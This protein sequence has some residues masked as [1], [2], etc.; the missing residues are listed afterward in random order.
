M[1]VTRSWSLVNSACVVIGLGLAVAGCAEHQQR[2]ET[3]AVST[4]QIQASAVA[5]APQPTGSDV[6][7]K[8]QVTAL[9][10][11][12]IVDAPD[13][14]PEDRALDAGRHPVEL[15]KF[16]DLRPGMKVAEIAAGGG[17]TTEL[18]A[19]AVGS[20]G[21]VFGQNSKFVLE[22]FAEKPWSERLKK[23]VMSNVIRVDQPFDDPLPPKAANFD[24]VINV[25]FYHDT[26][27]QKTDRA[28]MNRSIFEAL[29]SGG[30]YVIIDH[31]A[32]AGAGITEAETNHRI[33]ESVVREEIE[34]AGFRLAAS[35]DF[36]R[37]PNDTRD[38][39]ASPRV[40]GERRGTS[41]RFVLKFVKP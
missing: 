34:K 2:A 19:R 24:V 29:R 33:E 30:A 20:T 26:V 6:A 17:Y 7:P 1:K 13:R 9:S 38:W 27:W 10:A 4:V 40:A 22:R 28:R 12:A 16:I 21:A 35:A 11:Q 36:L 41:D 15:L 39:S 5:P 32:R 8:A 18:L 31:S 3:P 37:N 25:L 23:P 14:S